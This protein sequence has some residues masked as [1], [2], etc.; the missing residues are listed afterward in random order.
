MDFDPSV[1][2]VIAP[3]HL[4][5]LRD[6]PEKKSDVGDPIAARTPAC[7]RVLLDPMM[8]RQLDPSQRGFDATPAVAL[9]VRGTAA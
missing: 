3:V 5:A 2:G 7:A 6:C 8:Q 9:P 4:T 1:V